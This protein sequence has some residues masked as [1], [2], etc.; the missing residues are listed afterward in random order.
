M[1]LTLTLREKQSTFVQL[2]AQLI[3]YATR[4]GYS[5]TFGEA[6]RTPEQAAWNA[7]HGVGITASLHTKRLAIDLNLFD[8]EGVYLTKTDAY[9][10]LGIWWEAQST[11]D[12]T[13]AW[14][15]RFSRPDGNH[16]S[17]AH[18]GIR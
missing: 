7:A 12:Y 5:M 14:G 15:G 9:L 17:L 1:P 18:R 6:Y 8:S 16:F 3:E 13:C 2:V 10:L 11:P 4:H